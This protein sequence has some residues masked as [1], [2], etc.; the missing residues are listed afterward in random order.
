MK[1]RG[2]FTLGAGVVA[3]LAVVGAGIV[4]YGQW[5]Q[6]RDAVAAQRFAVAIGESAKYLERISVERG[7]HSQLVIARTIATPEAL[8]ALVIAQAETDGVIAGIREAALRLDNPERDDV[9]RKLGQAIDQVASARAASQ[10]EYLRDFSL[11][12]SDVGPALVRDFTK[13]A[14]IIHDII[15][16]I[17]MRLFETHPGVGRIMHAA[18]YANDL[19]DASGRRSTFLT[20]YV[21]SGQRFSPDVITQV[22]Q[23]TGQAAVHW[24]SLQHAIDQL[25]D[26]PALRAALAETQK[27]AR[28][29]GEKRYLALIKAASDGVAPD[30]S[31]SEWWNWS[32]AMLKSTLA[33]RDAATVEAVALAQRTEERARTRFMLSLLGL[34]GVMTVLACLVVL[35]SRKVVNPL[36]ELSET[37]A[38]IAR[39]DNDL[40]VPH[41][42]RSDEIGSMAKALDKVRIGAIEAKAFAEQADF[43]R[44]TATRAVRQELAAEFQT[45]VEGAVV[46][47]VGATRTIRA[48]SETS[49][50]LTDDMQAQSEQAS[51]DVRALTERVVAVS[52]AAEELASAIAE[53]ARQAD[54]ASSVTREAARQT[55]LAS[56]Q[57]ENLNGIS[58]RIDQIVGLIRSIADQT[59]LLALNATIEAARAGEAGRGF[60][61][62][63]AEVKGLA[64]QTSNATEDIGR[65]IAEMRAALG[66]S[67]ESIRRVSAQVPLIEQGSAAISAAMMQ[68]RSTTETISKE[69]S[70]AA[71]MTAAIEDATGSVLTS[72]TTAAQ[73][74]KAVLEAIGELDHRSETMNARTREFVDR[75]VA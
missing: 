12:P 65:Q 53:V 26:V 22:H 33:A 16:G 21:G 11:R 75:I 9:M 57:V 23:L 4:A 43:D 45:E 8:R 62:V 40:V 52:T 69:I 74:A 30:M 3:A 42:E 41:A 15:R 14:D 1:I 36:I 67:V 49:V 48:N 71:R 38:H 47:L 7:R 54:D 34:V 44:E 55:I 20:Q 70:D 24:R 6:L 59:N 37:V 51:Q 56:D 29:E 13:S 19:R 17:D 68:Q 10:R 5:A 60:A 39:G 31:V 28:G 27:L 18:R 32:Q 50:V 25:D 63:A 46:A 66:E 61:V 35:F 58:T 73:S 64:Q 72:A 2:L